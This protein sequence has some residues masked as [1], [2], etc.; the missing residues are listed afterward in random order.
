MAGNKKK[1]TVTIEV[2]ELIYDIENKT[3]LTGQAREEDGTKN[4]E[5]AS[6]IQASDDEDIGYQIRRSIERAFT[7]L[8]SRLCEYI[9]E[10]RT[11]SGNKI[12]EEIDN[13]GQLTLEFRLPESHNGASAESVGNEIHS[14]LVDTAISE[15]FSITDKED[16][17]AYAAHASAILQN[18][19]RALHQRTRPT[20]PKYD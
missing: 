2:K 10:E 7:T 15:W 19:E 20:R 13:D 1:L 9:Y 5:A 12:R 14:Y 6:N 4:Y 16:A 17:Q 8:K 18:A 11:T 3:H